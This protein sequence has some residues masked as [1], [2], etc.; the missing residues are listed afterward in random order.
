MSTS[1]P[2]HTQLAII[3]AGPAGYP[4]AFHAAARGLNVTLIDPRPNPGGVC[5]YAGCVPSKALLHVAGVLQELEMAPNWG[6]H[7][8]NLR[9]DLEQLRTWKDAV[10]NRLTRGLGQL[11]RQRKVSYIQGTARFRDNHSLE[12]SPKDADTYALGFNNAIIATGSI[13]VRS[14]GLGENSR[15]MTS[16]QAL[17][18]EEVPERLLVIGGGYIGLELGQVYAALGSA[19]TVVEKLDQLLP[20]IDRDLVQP[21]RK[22]LNRQFAAIYLQTEVTAIESADNALKC[23]FQAANSPSPEPAI[24]NRVMLAIGRRPNTDGI[25]LENTDVKLDAHGFIQV[26]TRR[27]T[28][29][30]HIYAIGDVAGEP[31]LAHKATHEA[32]VAVEALS[33]AKTAFAPRAIPAVVFSNPEIA[34]CGLSEREAREQQRPI[35]I[36]HFPWSASGRATTLDRTDG[37]TKLIL[38]PE[39]GRVLGLGITGVNAGELIGQGVMALEMGAVAEDLALMIQAHPTLSETIMEVG[40]AFVEQS[41]HYAGSSG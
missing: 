37:L 26:N 29:V 12:V 13:P 25:A 36:K 1:A 31:M 20:G 41:I 22:H 3:G 17:D 7:L 10:V 11:C 28:T 32:R 23:H 4:A 27:Q 5:L 8:E 18:L 38:N 21:L 15:L 2:N 33:G 6:V 35:V 39:D 34:W 14:A 30:E 9:I 16:E 40:A 24:F 19:V